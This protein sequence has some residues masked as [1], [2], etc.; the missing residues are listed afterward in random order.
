[1]DRAV[2]DWREPDRYGDDRA[3]AWKAAHYSEEI[4]G[5]NLDHV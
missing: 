4:V 2:P 5:S 1:M 3:G